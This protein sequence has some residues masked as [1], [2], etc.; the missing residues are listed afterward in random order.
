[1]KK[2]ITLKDEEGNAIYPC[3]FFPIGSIYISVINTNP[4][5]YFGGVW[6]RFAN[7][8]VLVGVDENQSEFAQVNK[9]GGNK[10]LQKHTHKYFRQRA[11]TAEP[12]AT[13]DKGTI[14]A[15]SNAIADFKTEVNTYSAGTG[16][17]GNLQPYIA[18]YMWRRVS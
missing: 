12:M 18:V 15:S 3:P 17:S 8:R 9:T 7:G 10:N 14:F 16:N 1:M 4:S 11:L 2:A 5:T 13:P 6:K